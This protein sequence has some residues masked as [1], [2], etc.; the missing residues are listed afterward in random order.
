MT[1]QWDLNLSSNESYLFFRKKLLEFIRP[2]G[3]C[4]WWIDDWVKMKLLYRLRVGGSH[5][6]EHKL[7]IIADT[8]NPFC[9]C[10]LEIE[11]TKQFFQL[12]AFMNELRDFD[13]FVLCDI[14]Y[15]LRIMVYGDRLFN[16]STSKTTLTTAIKQSQDT[17][18]LARLY[19]ELIKLFPYKLKIKFIH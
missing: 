19:F 13:T 8:W 3:N 7:D 18:D 11:C 9:S 12:T 15:L 1:Q 16:P 4:T 2:T 5:L 10:A 17:K 14:N 6:P